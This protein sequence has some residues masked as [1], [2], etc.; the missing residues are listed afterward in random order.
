MVRN[1]FFMY[2]LASTI[3]LMMLDIHRRRAAAALGAQ[4]HGGSPTPPA[5]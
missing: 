2:S 3:P 4:R 1:V 5:L